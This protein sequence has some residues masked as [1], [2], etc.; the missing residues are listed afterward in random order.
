M[1]GCQ[2]F[3]YICLI[4]GTLCLLVHLYIPHL[5]RFPHLSWGHWGACIHLSDISVLSVHLS[6]NSYQ[7]L[8]IT[9]GCLQSPVWLTLVSMCP[10]YCFFFALLDWRSTNV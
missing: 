7:L 6:I 8:N 9:V 10:G 3:W 2:A 4:R 1:G 5:I